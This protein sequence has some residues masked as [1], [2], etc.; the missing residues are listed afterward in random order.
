MAK[1]YMGKLID[2]KLLEKNEEGFVC[3]RWCNKS[4]KPPRKTMCSPECVHELSLRING[5]YLRDCIYKRDKGI[6]AMCNIDTKL[7][8]KN[9]LLLIANKENNKEDKIEEYMKEYGI[10]KKRKIWIKKHG[11]GLW[12]GDHII[13][14]KDGGGLCGLENMR[15]LCIKC[16]KGV[17]ASMYCK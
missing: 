11:G 10:S 8:A 15:T 1:R 7:T 14:V 17:T 5:R 9:L 4:V 2:A 13:P 12:D 3:C 16:H 6:C